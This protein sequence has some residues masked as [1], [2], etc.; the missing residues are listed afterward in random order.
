MKVFWL[1]SL[2]LIVTMSWAALIPRTSYA[3]SSQQTSADSS[4]PTPVAG[5]PS[6]EQRYPHRASD[7]NHPRNRASLSAATHRKQLPESRTRS[8]PGNAASLHQHGAGKSGAAAK[9]GLIQNET[10]RN[11]MLVRLAGTVRPT[12][13]SL[14]PSLNNVRHRGPNPAVVGGSAGGSANLHSSN[15]GAINGTRMKRK[16]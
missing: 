5:N 6:K 11:A 8:T 3:V 14:N 10:G 12:A 4:A 1:F 13:A 7:K 15:T 2:C 9:G 16:P